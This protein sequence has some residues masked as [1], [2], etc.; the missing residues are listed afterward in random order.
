MNSRPG[1]FRS[2]LRGV[3]LMLDPL[4]HK[5]E[6]VRASGTAS[7]AEKIDWD[8]LPRTHFAYGMHRA[9]LQAKGL[10]I[11]RISAIE[12]GCAGGNGLVELERLAATVTRE[13]G[14]EFD[15]FGFDM[16][17]GLPPPQDYRDLPYAWQTGQFKMDVAALNARLK[18]TN[19]VLGNVEETVPTF[20]EGGNF[21]P[22]GFISFDLDYYSST[23][24]ALRI[25]EGGF[26]HILPRVYCY[27]DDIIG[28]DHEL[29][30]EFAGELLA[31]SEFNQR[32]T[33]RKLAPIHGLAYKR[34]LPAAWND[35]MMVLHAFDHPLYSRYLGN[36]QDFD[37]KL[38][39]SE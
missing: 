18:K 8:A 30:S 11:H 37:F 26:K 21:A 14:I 4:K 22:I 13:V 7:L 28:P 24:H 19:L 17:E 2:L 5:Q 27:F 29:H 1:P 33:T 35:A 3:R 12:F 34:I 10:G 25:L 32:H 39:L 20:R 36:T 9:A 16:G 31:I 6:R 38:A 23:A 15:I